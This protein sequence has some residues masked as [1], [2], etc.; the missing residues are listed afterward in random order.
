MPFD[1]DTITIAAAGDV[2]I[3]QRLREADIAA[4][5]PLLD[6]ADITIANLDGVLSSLGTP[7]P[8]FVNL[9][10]PREA[11]WDVRALGIDIVS[12]ANNH[13][14]D[15]RAEGML[16]MRQALLEAGVHPVGAGC[17]LTEAC[18]PA[19]VEV[20]GRTVAILAISCTLPE[21]AAAGPTW[22]GIAPLRI[23]T[24]YH[25]DE[26]LS[27]EQ[28]G[29][30][31]AV[32]T[33]PDERQ[34]ARARADVAQARTI[35]DHVI[36]V[37]HWGVPAPWRAPVQPLVQEYQRQV[38]HALIDAGADAIVGIHAHELHGIE[39]YRNRPIAYCL[40]NFWVDSLPRYPWLGRES[41][42]LRIL[43]RKDAPP[44]TELVPIC[45][46][47]A[48]VPRPDPAARAITLLNARSQEFAVGIETAG[49]RFRV[50]ALP[51]TKPDGPE[52]R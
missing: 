38:G 13:A 24:A 21:G 41:I 9:R 19:L 44:E 46:D 40:S 14:M 47:E 49:Q 8:K 29:S 27:L 3:E 12:L 1:D 26:S 16:D 32:R 43:L 50:R 17:S 20:R 42:V 48:G 39:L 23:H 22:P 15:F 34:L 4:V 25:V 51:S 37:V 31:P 35:A 10:G 5:R 18:A 6:G 30:V 52:S 33:W 28:P 45:L 36:M 7:M 2:M 11:A